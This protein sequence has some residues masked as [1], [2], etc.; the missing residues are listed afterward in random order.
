MYEFVLDKAWNMGISDAQWVQKLAERRIGRKDAVA[1]E[2]WKTL[3]DSIYVQNSYSSQTP[4]PC[5][6]PCLEGYWHWVAK[7]MIEFDNAT[8][9]RALEKLLTVESDRDTYRFDVVNIGTQAL[10]NH[11]ET[12]RD[13]L[14][15]AY[16]VKDAARVEAV[17]KVMKELIA[18]MDALAAC[19]PQLSLERWL[20]DASSCAKTEEEAA[21]YRRNARTI[22]STW[23][24]DCSIRD[25]CSR[26]WSGLLK[27]YYSP[28]WEMFVEELLSCIDEEREYSQE[29]FFKRL[30]EFEN[31]WA[32]Q[33]QHIDYNR[34][35]EYKS[36]AKELLEKYGL[37][38]GK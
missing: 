8:L 26:G 9:V 11:F 31:Q 2:V 35:V 12:L 7:H 23:G 20:A 10:G 4:L 14:A 3:T 28:R 27:S 36:L 38:S 32:A 17:G 5:A 13:E 15:A 33:Q 1:E 19:E 22:V 30:T 6:R 34:P 24:N 25:Y 16:R 21:Y 18:D 29:Q 37:I